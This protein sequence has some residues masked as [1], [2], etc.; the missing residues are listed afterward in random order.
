MRSLLLAFALLPVVSSAA[1]VRTNDSVPT[2]VWRSVLYPES[3]DSRLAEPRFEDGA[4]LQDF[5]RAGYHAGESVLPRPDGPLI[6]VTT[7][8][9]SADRTGAA[10]STAAIQRAIDDAST[11][12]GG[13]VLLPEGRYLLSVAEGRREALRITGDN[14]VLR[15]AGADRTFLINS[16]T[17]MRSRAVIRVASN[18]GRGDFFNSKGPASPVTAN[19]LT[20]TT[21]IPVADTS[22]FHPGDFVVIT[23][24]LTDAWIDEAGDPSWKTDRN[25][26]RAPIYFREVVAVDTEGGVLRVDTPIRN[27]LKLRD[28]PTVRRQPAQPLHEVGLEDFSIGNRQIEGGGWAENDH[29]VEGTAAHDAH[30]SWLITFERA[31]DCWAR[32]VRSHQPGG[33]TSGAHLLSNGILLHQTSRVTLADC[34]LSRPQY[35]GGGGNGYLYRL[36]H[37]NDSLLI[38]CRGDFSRHGFVFSHAGSNGN[39]L[40][41]CV[42]AR[43]GRACGSDGEYRT[44]GKGSDHHMQFSHANLIDRCT[45]DDSWWEARYRPYPTGSS[46]KHGVTSAHTVFWNIEGLGTVRA[47]VVIS[48]QAM[49]GYVIGTRGPRHSVDLP[50]RLPSATDPVDHVEGMGRGDSLAPSSLYLDQLRRRGVAP[51]Q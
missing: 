27:F 20:P 15:G 24:E 4:F 47:P 45:A 41:D 49:R 11:R 8:P 2:P 3:D 33:N 5:S 22:L 28:R 40:H 1:A 48:E 32:R 39:V 9:Y 7:P 21:V 30:A 14:I 43:T 34:A 31:R 6:D 37:A 16:T 35:G 25:R 23:H 46:L 42:D 38:R 19:L 50:S 10:D 12:G 44:A 51:L 17:R 29:A 18:G 26:P 13:V 36:Q